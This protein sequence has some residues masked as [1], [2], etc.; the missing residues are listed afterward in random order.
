M[1]DMTRDK[2]FNMRLTPDEW[3]RF[4]AVAAAH[5]LPV[6]TVLRMLMK[7]EAD[8]LTKSDELRPAKKARKGAK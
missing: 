3:A 1:L 5:E 8:R 7:Q 4:E 6:A 2:T